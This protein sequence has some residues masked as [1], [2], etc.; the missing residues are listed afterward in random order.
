[1]APQADLPKPRFFLG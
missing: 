1:L